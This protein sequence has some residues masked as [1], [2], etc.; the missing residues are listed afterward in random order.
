MN[1]G[2]N[3]HLPQVHELS[4]QLRNYYAVKESSVPGV[5]THVT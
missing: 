5:C 4:G 3:I 1:K 2:V